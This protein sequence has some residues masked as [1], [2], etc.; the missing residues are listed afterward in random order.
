MNMAAMISAIGSA[1]RRCLLR[2]LRIKVEE[3]P[4]AL[5]FDRRPSLGLPQQLRQLRHVGR[6]APRLLL[7]IHLTRG[8]NVANLFVSGASMVEPGFDD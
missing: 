5:L 1:Y 2:A 8:H 7:Q 6:N 4:A 3:N